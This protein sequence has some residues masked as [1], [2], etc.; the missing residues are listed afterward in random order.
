MLDY[1]FLAPEVEMLTRAPLP[2]DRAPLPGD[3]I[4]KKERFTFNPPQNTMGWILAD[5]NENRVSIFSFRSSTW[6][7]GGYLP[8]K[9]GISFSD[10]KSLLEKFK[11][12]EIALLTG[13]KTSETITETPLSQGFENFYGEINFESRRINERTFYT[14]DYSADRLDGKSLVRQKIYLYVLPEKNLRGIYVIAMITPKDKA[15]E[16]YSMKTLLNLVHIF[17]IKEG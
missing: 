17:I 12:G 6:I 1:S 4:Y 13:K 14:A 16:K 15:K 5:E 9:S 2:G 10:E 7:S 11:E 8:L 3:F